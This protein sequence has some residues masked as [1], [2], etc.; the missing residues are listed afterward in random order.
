MRRFVARH[1]RRCAIT[2]VIAVA[3]IAIVCAYVTNLLVPTAP[4]PRVV[5][6]ASLNIIE[7]AGIVNSDQTIG[8]S[9]S[10]I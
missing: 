1:W 10:D 9:H 7:T 2:T 8:M 3:A 5:S 4:L 6:A